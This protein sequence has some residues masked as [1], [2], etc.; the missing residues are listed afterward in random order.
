VI[1]GVQIQEVH[2]EMDLGVLVHDNL[3]CAQQCA[4]VVGKALKVLG[5]IRRTLKNFSSNV[6]M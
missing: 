5:M 1:D 6:V 3:K 2:E 4:K